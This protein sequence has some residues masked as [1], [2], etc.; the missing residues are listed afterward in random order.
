MHLQLTWYGFPIK[1]DLKECETEL[2]SISASGT[3]HTDY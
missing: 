1:A 2:E 3:L